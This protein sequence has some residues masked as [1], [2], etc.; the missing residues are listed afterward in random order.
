MLPKEINKSTVDRIKE[1]S[2]LNLL[3]KKSVNKSVIIIDRNPSPLKRYRFT[4]NSRDCK[5]HTYNPQAKEMNEISFI[6]K[7]QYSYPPYDGPV[8]LDLIFYMQ[9]P[10][11]YSK[12]KKARLVNTYH[13][14]HLDLDNFIKKIC[15]ASNGVLFIDDCQVV[16]INAKKV[17]AIEGKTVMVMT[18][19]N[20]E[21]TSSEENTS[22]K[23]TSVED[24]SVE[25]EE[26]TS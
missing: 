7:S 17:W 12:I 3:K 6:I 24:A 18:K 4:N 5:G 26:E 8:S 16:R 13:T 23:D 22:V 14:K 11:S 9:L 10:R 2:R 20:N 25:E 19:E 15:D 21:Q 1:Y